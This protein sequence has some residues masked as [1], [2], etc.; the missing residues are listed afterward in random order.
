MARQRTLWHHVR[1]AT[2]DPSR[3]EPYGRLDGH[4]LIVEDDR[5]VSIAPL[6]SLSPASFDGHVVD[7]GGRWVTP[8]LIDCHTHLVYGGSRAEEWEKRLT[9]V[10]Y[11]TIAREGGGILSTV[12]ATRA[13]DEE[14]LFQ[15][16]L[17][18][19]KAL[20]NE[21]VTCIEIKSGYGLDLDN[22]LKQLRVARRLGREFAVEIA[23]TLLAAHAVPPEFVGDA[24]GWIERI[25]D[26]LIPA[27]ASAGLA[28]AV[29]VFCEGVGFSVAQCRRVFDAARAH[30][31]A[32]KAHAEQ[33][34]HRG[35]AQLVADCGGLSADHLEHLDAA[36]VHRM[37]QA[38]TVAV[39]LPGAF[40]FLRETS[41]PPV[42]A[43]RRAGV[44]MAVSS[45]LNPGTS[46]F[47]SLRLA[48][49]Q[50]CVLFGLTP[51][52][53]LAGAT[54]HAA[55]ALGRGTRMGVLAEGRLADFLVWSVDHPSEIVYS[56]GTPLLHQRVFRG[57]AR[58]IALE[59]DS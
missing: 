7:G 50:A 45:D 52:E 22:E 38:G 10:P 47:A 23:P 8:G 14:G 30:S 24:D 59:S 41:R 56:L 44:P 13:L 20:M 2:M 39:L 6:S 9:G 26:T 36:G 19:L 1:L 16:S 25:A 57:V 11:E 4:A 31:L 37:A 35:G 58:H 42:E 48:M 21:G 3:P 17:P 53:A 43:L 51:E 34:S 18:R 15:A 32:V 28:E 55:R 29:D 46:P 49:N 12:R 27:A 54:R 5:V 40:Y 33:L